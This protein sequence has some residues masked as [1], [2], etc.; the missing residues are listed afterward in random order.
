M[1]K[2]QSHKLFNKSRTKFYFYP[3]PMPK[4]KSGTCIVVP[5]INRENSLFWSNEKNKEGASGSKV[6]DGQT[7]SLHTGKWAVTAVK[8]GQTW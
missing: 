1:G 2:I 5:T 7:L 3:I 4:S 6:T 8:G